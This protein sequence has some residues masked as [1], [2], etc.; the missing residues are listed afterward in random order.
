MAAAYDDE[1][2]TRHEEG[3]SSRA[4]FMIPSATPTRWKLYWVGF[5]RDRTV[6]IVQSPAAFSRVMLNHWERWIVRRFRARK[7]ARK[8]QA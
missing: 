5:V 8:D 4:I 2:K 1:G 3:V 6:S 7:G